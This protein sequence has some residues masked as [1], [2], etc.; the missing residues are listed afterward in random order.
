MYNLESMSFDE[1]QDLQKKAAELAERK[2]LEPITKAITGTGLG[3]L[4]FG[5]KLVEL[6]SAEQAKTLALALLASNYSL[7]A[8][9]SII[10]MDEEKFA[11]YRKPGVT[12][13]NSSPPVKKT[14]KPRDTSNLVRKEDLTPEELEI[15][16]NATDFSQ[17]KNLPPGTPNAGK[18]IVIGIYNSIKGIK[19][20][21][22]RT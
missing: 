16:R 7:D 12:V 21:R 22:K 1:L 4:E 5:L 13:Q 9:K 6:L 2:R 15:I 3:E 11:V 19:V 20:Q 14:R 18:Q 10:D 8:A 17:V